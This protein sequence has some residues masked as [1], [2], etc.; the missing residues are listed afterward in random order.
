MFFASALVI[1]QYRPR[2]INP[3]KDPGIHLIV[4]WLRIGRRVKTLTTTGD[5]TPAFRAHILVCTNY[6]V[7]ATVFLSTKANIIYDMI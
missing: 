1:H 3:G 7:P 5:R 6:A 2:P 4:G